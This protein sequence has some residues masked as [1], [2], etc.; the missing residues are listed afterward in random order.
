M[1]WSFWKVNSKLIKK[2][3]VKQASS[4]QVSRFEN[5]LVVEMLQQPQKRID[6]IGAFIKS[7]IDGFFN[8]F[9]VVIRT[10]QLLNALL[11]FM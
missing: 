4:F 6:G 8:N 3:T 5:I 1:Y 10:L 7:K 11:C 9:W 2:R